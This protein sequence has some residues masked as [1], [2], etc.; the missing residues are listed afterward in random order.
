MEYGKTLVAPI[1]QA[2][3]ELRT[4]AQERAER[5]AKPY[6]GHALY[7]PADVVAFRNWAA[8]LVS[9]GG[10]GAMSSLLRD[11]KLASWTARFERTYV[12]LLRARAAIETADMIDGKIVRM[13]QDA[14]R[15]ARNEMATL[16]G[17]MA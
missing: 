13:Q 2:L 14:L 11:E 12:G 7:T 10:A 16:R 3:I 8:N 1:N 5:V 4:M 15:V 9:F 6:E 17:T